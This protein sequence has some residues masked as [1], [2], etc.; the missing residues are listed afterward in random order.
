M[1]G[2]RAE[3]SAHH[4]NVLASMVGRWLKMPHEIVCVTDS[5][6]GIDGGVRIV[7]L[8]DDLREHGQCFLR[9]K[10]F[11]PEMRDVFNDR[12]ISLDLDTV[13]TGPLDPLFDRP[14]PFVALRD[15]SGFAP[16]CGSQWLLAVGSHSEVFTRFDYEQWRLL[17]PVRG[18]QGSDQAW[19]SYMIPDAPTWTDADGVYSFKDHIC[20]IKG[21]ILIQLVRSEMQQIRLRSLPVDAR[22]VHFHGLYDPSRRFI[23]DMIPWVDEHWK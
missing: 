15:P 16:Y 22:I 5:P 6:D 4:V 7:P 3:Y 19:I 11:A 14:E 8:W 9:L 13:V 12:M 20:G 2:A 10:A 1:G 23:R 18:W 21:P 17:K